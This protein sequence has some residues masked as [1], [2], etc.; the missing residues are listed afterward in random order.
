M[1]KNE[2]VLLNNNEQVKVPT[3]NVQICVKIFDTYYVKET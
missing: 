1:P 2:N 3:F